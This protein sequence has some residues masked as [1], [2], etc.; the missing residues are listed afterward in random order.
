M[1]ALPIYSSLSSSGIVTVLV[2]VVV[3]FIC[4]CLSADIQLCHGIPA[5]NY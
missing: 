1:R 4:N 2:S 5:F 3:S